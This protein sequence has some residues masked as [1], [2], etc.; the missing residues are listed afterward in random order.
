MALTLAT[1]E[2]TEREELRAFINY[3]YGIRYF[4]VKF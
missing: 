2:C 1:N 3:F 4:N